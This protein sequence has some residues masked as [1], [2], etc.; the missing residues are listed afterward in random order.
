MRVSRHRPDKSGIL[1]VL[2]SE[3]DTEIA[4]A[5]RRSSAQMQK[6]SSF[7]DETTKSI[8]KILSSFSMLHLLMRPQNP[9]SFFQARHHDQA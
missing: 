9:S 5:L 1:R 3:T 2:K 7:T 8:Y 6:L 4:V